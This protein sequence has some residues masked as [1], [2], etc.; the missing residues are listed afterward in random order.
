MFDD[1]RNKWLRE[2]VI[3][4]LSDTHY[5]HNTKETTLYEFMKR[6]DEKYPTVAWFEQRV[7]QYRK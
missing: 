7:D 1:A 2:E 3:L 6:F 5:E 4:Y